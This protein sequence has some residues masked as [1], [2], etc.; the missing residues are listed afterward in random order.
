[1]LDCSSTEVS[2]PRGRATGAIASRSL[3]S[4]SGAMLWATEDFTPNS[5][6]HGV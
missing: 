4:T 5:D 3:A 6:L 1:M 2:T